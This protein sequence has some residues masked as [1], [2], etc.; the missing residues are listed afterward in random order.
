MAD[1]PAKL[2]ELPRARV[3]RIVRERIADG[4]Y[5]AGSQLPPMDEIATELGVS[6]GSVAA[7]LRSM[8]EVEVIAGYGSFVRT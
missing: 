4:T 2:P 8:P 5:T 7:A 6:R 1:V 3:E